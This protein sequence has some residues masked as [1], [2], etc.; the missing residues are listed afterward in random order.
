MF[1]YLLLGMITV[2]IFIKNLKNKINMKWRKILCWL[3]IKH[4]YIKCNDGISRKFTSLGMSYGNCAYCNRFLI[5][6]KLSIPESYKKE[7]LRQKRRYE[8]TAYEKFVM[9]EKKNYPTTID[10]HYNVSV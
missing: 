9:I 10:N 7:L 4:T 2:I 8:L 6:H 3:N 5:E 1:K